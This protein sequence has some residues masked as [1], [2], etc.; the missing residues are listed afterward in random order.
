MDYNT[1]NSWAFEQAKILLKDIN[2]KT[3]DKGYVLFCTGYGPSGLPHI[4][5]FGEIVRTNYVINAFKKLAPEIPIKLI[6]ISDDL[7]GMRKIPGNVPN[8]DKLREHLFKPLTSVPD[9]FQ[10][11]ESFGDHGNKKLIEFLN[12]FNFKY[13]FLSATKAYKSGLFNDALKIAARKYQDLMNLMLPTLGTERQSTYHPFIPIDKELG[14]CIFSDVINLDLEKNTIKYKLNGKEKEISFLNGNCK[15]Q[16]KCDFGM[17]WVALAVDFEIYGKDH[18]PNDQLYKNIAKTIGNRNPTTFFYELFLDEEGKKI[19]KT[20]GNGTS[21]ETWLRYVNKDVLAYYM[22]LKPQTAK[23]L[24][25]D[26]IPKVA[27]EY[28]TMLNKFQTEID[29]KKKIENPVW[30]VHNENPSRFDS[31]ISFSLIINLASICGAENEEILWQFLKKY[32]KNLNQNDKLLNDLIKGGVNYYNDFIKNT[33]IDYKIED[34]NTKNAI[35]KL[36]LELENLNDKTAVNIQ[37]TTYEVG[38]SFN[39]ELQDW[40]SSLYKILTGIEK[41]P[42]IGTLIA[43]YGLDKCINKLKNK[44]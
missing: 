15:L 36:I 14:I 7:D 2:Y 17:R 35:K 32:D 27:D 9:P 26:I 12:R 10:E 8:Q 34:E 22:Y 24:Y 13:E 37:N 33:K 30:H 40:F 6:V 29:E 44:I 1:V 16:W 4:G 5:T 38:K 11:C 42:R 23:R 25:F 31:E 43:I 20:K 19:S 28:L 18:W 21:V 39:I 3:P 41:G